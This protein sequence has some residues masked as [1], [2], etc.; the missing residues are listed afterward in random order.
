MAELPPDE[1]TM[2]SEPVRILLVEDSPSDAQLLQES[3]GETG[4]GRFEFVQAACWAEGAERLRQ[5]RFDVLL[6]DLSLPDSSGRQTFVRARAAAPHLPIVVLTG[7]ADESIA[8][9]ALRQGVQDYLVK[10]RADGPQTARSIRYAIERHRIEEA[11]KRAEA[12]LRQN[13]RQLREWNLELERRVAARTAQLEETIG[14]LEHFSHSI[15]HDLRAPLR[16]MR[17]FAQLLQEDCATCIKAEAQEN[18]QHI[19]TAAARMDKLIEDV[20]QFSRL[21]RN[22]LP[23]TPVDVAALLRGIIQSYPAFHSSQVEIQLQE[24]LP[25]VLGNEAALTQCFSNLLDNAVK[26]VAPGKVPRIC[27]RADLVQSPKPGDEGTDAGPAA[28]Q[29]ATRNTPPSINYVRLWV[30]DNG[31]GIPK[32]SQ[33]RIF[34]LFQ[35]LSKQYAGT[36]VGLAVVRKAVEKMGGQIGVESAP[37]QGSRFWLELKAADEASAPGPAGA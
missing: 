24:P 1:L 17:I 30:E 37:G 21:A 20:L 9:D 7:V 34:R 28:T 12:A 32:E 2:N 31:I 18:T 22:E 3:L 25:R 19:I 26:F 11:L 8:L 13:E 6:L 14:D 15:A 33:E 23:L 35:Q 16:A 4:L 5:G 29:H 27:I 36:G 10:G